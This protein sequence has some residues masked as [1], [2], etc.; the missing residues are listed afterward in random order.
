[1]EIEPE[2]YPWLSIAALA[3]G[4]LDCF[5]GYRVFKLT[6]ALLGAVI[7]ALLGQAGALALGLD[8][9][10]ELA[11]MLLGALGGA[12]LA[13]LLYLAAVFMA[14]FGF[15]A[16]LAVLLLAHFNH[17]VALL[18]AIVAGLVGGFAAVKLQKALLV[19]ATA[20]L[21]SFRAIVA[22]TFFTAGLDWM[23]YYRQPQQIP[24][25]IDGNAWMFPAILVLA[26][27][28][29]MVQFEVGTSGGDNGKAKGKK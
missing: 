10:G 3:W 7:G 25:L 13:F 19:L 29:A 14:G 8:S 4:V 24:A 26:A 18:A 5:F 9:T 16:T 12:G 21:G 11:G 20:L 15:G 27:I 28:G 2:L 17:M 23:Y 1:M 6:I 22:L